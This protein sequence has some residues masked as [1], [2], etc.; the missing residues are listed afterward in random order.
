MVCESDSNK[1]TRRRRRRK[2]RRGGGGRGRRRRRGEEEEGSVSMPKY[3]SLCHAPHQVLTHM[4]AP[5]CRR[6]NGGSEKLQ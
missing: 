5:I 2:K 3:C 6:V 1:S 4:L